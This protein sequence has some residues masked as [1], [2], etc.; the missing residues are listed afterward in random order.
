M[1]EKENG[2]KNIRPFNGLIIND[3]LKQ[4]QPNKSPEMKNSR[5]FVYSKPG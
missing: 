2:K 3:D 5:R 4:L 1:A